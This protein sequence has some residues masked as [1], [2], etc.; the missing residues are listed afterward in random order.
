MPLFDA[1]AGDNKAVVDR[2]LRPRF[3]HLGTYF[4]HRS[5]SCRYIRRDIV[6]KHDI[7]SV[8]HA[9]CGLVGLDCKK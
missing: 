2:R 1:D 9:H 5:F 3:Y 6:C 8:Q 4:K 7:I